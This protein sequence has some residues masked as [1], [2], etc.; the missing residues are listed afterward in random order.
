[1][2]KTR[3]IFLVFLPALMVAAFVFFI[4]AI[5]YEPLSPKASETAE[6]PQALQIP[7]FPDDPM[8]GDKKAPITLIAFEDAGCAACAEQH[9]MFQKL[10]E[11]YP[12]KIKIIWKPLPVTLIPY[13]SG[14]AH[15]YAYCANQQEKFDV[16]VT[17]AFENQNDLSPVA[18]NRLAEQ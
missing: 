12:K 7:I 11:T 16:F 9:A 5:Q 15:E 2:L 1:M 13:P 17:L 18:L 10:L 8:L 3:H 4:R 6:E 14:R